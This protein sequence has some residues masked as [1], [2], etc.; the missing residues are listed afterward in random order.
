MSDLPSTDTIVELTQLLYREASLLDDGQFEDWLTLLED[1]FQYQAP[2]RLD[3]ADRPKA[4]GGGD[5]LELSFFE[6]TKG[7][8][9]LRIAKIRTGL[10][11]TENPAS[12]VVRIISNV[13]V[14]PE[15]A[16]GEHPVRSAFLIYR[17]H[18]QRDVE[19]LAGHRHDLWKRRPDGWG[20]ARR[21]VMF[22]ANVL[23]VKSLPLIY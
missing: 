16:P 19:I 9:Q 12:R 18:R 6:D 2:I 10:M 13:Q 15:A 14:Y 20:M 22:A 5:K 11:Q 21:R 1:D 3:L 23:P 8:M 7:T 17:Q 4:D